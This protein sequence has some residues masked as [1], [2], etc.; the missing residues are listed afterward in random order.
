MGKLED[1]LQKTLKTEDDAKT[2]KRV[3]KHLKDESL[4]TKLA[5]T[6]SKVD[7]E[8]VLNYLNARAEKE[9]RM[10]GLKG[11][12][13]DLAETPLN[14]KNLNTNELTSEVCKISERKLHKEGAE[15]TDIE[16][17]TKAIVD[18]IDADKARKEEKLNKLIDRMGARDLD[19][20]TMG[21]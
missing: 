18:E 15:L 20:P 13:S 21:E 10:N 16:V 8:R 7:K 3:I 6:T 5:D 11:K 17:K 19:D 2:V 12:L 4:P 9:I 1:D 14:S